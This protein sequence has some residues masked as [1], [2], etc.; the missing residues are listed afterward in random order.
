MYSFVK[1]FKG[2]CII[3]T[4]FLTSLLFFSCRSGSDS[5]K[6]LVKKVSVIMVKTQVVT[7]YQDYAAAIEG[8]NNIEIRPQFKHSGTTTTVTLYDFNNLKLA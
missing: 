4:Y 7:T 1:G 3:I 8:A 6:A 2:L 5:E